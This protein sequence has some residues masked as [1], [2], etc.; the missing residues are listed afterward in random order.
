[1]GFIIFCIG[2]FILTIAYEYIST[3]Y[4]LIKGIGMISIIGFENKY[5]HKLMNKNLSGILK[6]DARRT[7]EK[8]QKIS[9]KIREEEGKNF[10]YER[11]SAFAILNKVNELKFKYPYADASL[12]SKYKNEF[13]NLTITELDNLEKTIAD[14][15]IANVRSG[16]QVTTNYTYSDIESL[17]PLETKSEY[18][19]KMRMY[20]MDVD[21][22]VLIENSVTNSVS[23]Y[24]SRNYMQIL[25]L[26]SN[27][28]NEI[29]R[30]RNLKQSI[31]SVNID[32]IIKQNNIENIHK[33]REQQIIDR[34]NNGMKNKKVE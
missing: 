11:E 2:F 6:E 10:Q 12:I 27:T 16:K 26:C 34:M 3:I 29:Y 5:K 22:I 17:T 20:R 30:L 23:M 19:L 25:E 28:L 31:Q 4:G 8:Q 33:I 18:P 14:N 13:I 1:M 7:I 32:N 24:Q 21:Y 9:N 15:H